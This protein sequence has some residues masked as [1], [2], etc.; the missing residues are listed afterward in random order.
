MIHPYET[1]TLGYGLAIFHANT[2]HRGCVYV[3]GIM[4]GE[5]D[6]LDLIQLLITMWLTFSGI[7][8]KRRPPQR[9][10]LKDPSSQVASQV[11]A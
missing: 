7:V 9:V 10:G 5:A 11:A 3:R 8:C 4:E 2:T 6:R 1:N